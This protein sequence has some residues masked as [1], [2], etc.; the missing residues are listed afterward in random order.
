MLGISVVIPVYN[1]EKLLEEAIRSVVE[2]DYDGII[3]VVVADD[4]STD[5]SLDLAA[6][7]GDKVRI[8]PKP[9]TCLSQGVSGTR[10]RGIAA[11]SQPYIAFLDSDDFYLPNHLNRMAAALAARRELGFVFARVL[12]MREQAGGRVY[13]PWTCSRMTDR[14]IRYLGVSG[15]SV[16]HTSAFLFRREVFEK[17]GVFNEAYSNGEDGDLWMRISEEFRGEFLD[18]YG[19]VYRTAHGHGQL[20]DS[21]KNEAIMSCLRQIYASAVERYHSNPRKDRFRIFRLR[22]LHTMAK[23][24]RISTFRKWLGLLGVAGLHPLQSAVRYLEVLAGDRIAPPVDELWQRLEA[25]VP[26][27]QGYSD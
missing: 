1:R 11:A 4:G 23:H 17:V 20:T 3:E 21:D 9:Q 16:V 27:R 7:F 24:D 22:L 19:S 15:N 5:R 26:E 13:A 8:L 18:H 25:F 12:M 2:Q 6:S 10:N 14:H